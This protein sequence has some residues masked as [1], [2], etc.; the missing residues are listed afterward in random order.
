MK[1][2]A[3]ESNLSLPLG[4]LPTT[5][6]A[7]LFAYCYFRIP[8]L[9]L[10]LPLRYLKIGRFKYTQIK[11]DFLARFVEERENCRSCRGCIRPSPIAISDII[12][13]TQDRRRG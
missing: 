4:C 11:H 10:Q 7:L 8:P 3:L 6:G 2:T 12:L 5:S 9:L 13:L 1:E